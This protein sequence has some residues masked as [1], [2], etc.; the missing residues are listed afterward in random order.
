MDESVRQ[1]PA[2]AALE[3]LLE[4]VLHTQ[5]EIEAARKTVNLALAK[6]AAYD[7]LM[8]KFDDDPDALKKAM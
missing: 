1:D 5:P 4:P 8:G 2:R 3:V 7:A 6:A